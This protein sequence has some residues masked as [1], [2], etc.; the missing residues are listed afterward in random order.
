MWQML[1]FLVLGG[2]AGASS[3]LLGIGGG[4]IMVPALVVLFGFI[5]QTAQGTALAVMIPAALMGAYT[6]AGEQKVN[7]PVAA[8]MAVG[9]IVA[10]RYGATLALILPR[11]VLRTLFALLMVIAA[12]RMMPKGTSTEMGLLAGV[13]ALAAVLRL[14][15][16]R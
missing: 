4:V 2:V 6:Y 5:Q 15:V 16:L 14:F 12:V 11:E 3:G 1:A 8:V 13:L 7:L 10:A 9:A